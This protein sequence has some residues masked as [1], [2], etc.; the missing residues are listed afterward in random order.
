MRKVPRSSKASAWNEVYALLLLGFGTL[1]FLAL[2]SFTPKDVP[3]WV[4]FSQVATP[5]SP[6]QNFI[7]PVGAIVA[8]SCYFIIG[9]AA[10]LLAV[11]LLGFGGAK[12]FHPSLRVTPRTVWIVLFIASGA[13]LL[14]LQH[15]FLTDWHSVFNIQGPGG[16]VGYYLGRSVLQKLMGRVGS[17]LLLVGVYVSAL[18]LM[19]GLRPIH[20]VRQTVAAIRSGIAAL[21]AWKLRRELRRADIKGR[22]EISRR[23]L[24]KQQRTLEKQLKKKGAPVAE[25]VTSLIPPEELLNRPKPKVVDTTALP[26]E[27]ARKKPSLAELRGRE[28]K[29]TAPGPASQNWDAENYVL[30]SV[31]LLDEHDQEGRGATD[32]AE[33]EN[34]QKVLIDTLA[35]FDIQVAAGD[36][37]KGPTIT[38]YEVYPARGVRVDKIVSLERDLARATRAERIN[39][40]APIPGKDTVGIELANSRKVKVTL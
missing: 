36:I 10:Y 16:S 40:L 34:I 31:D 4:W 3:S 24:A 18:I 8:G 27:P 35:Q 7:G 13:C 2:V 28:K 22:L 19:T 21:H 17:L 25:Q 1:L 20:I 14:Q 15:R 29:E 26:D 5:N 11:V 23:E 12:L 38:R 6:A 32:P 33:L 39:I 30:P 37:T 9:A